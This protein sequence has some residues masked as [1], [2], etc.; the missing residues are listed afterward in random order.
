[1][2]QFT[3]SG[4][5]FDYIDQGAGEPVLLIHGF[6]S[7]LAV[8]WVSTG[9]TKALEQAGYRVIAFDNRGHGKSS[10]SHD[11]D[12]YQ[13]ELMAADAVALL[14][15]LGI[16]RAHV[17]GYSMGARIAAFMALEHPGRVASLI[18]GG[19]G[20][21][22]VE[23]V[24]DWGPIAKALVADD[25]DLISDARAQAFRKFADQTKSDKK[26]LAACIKTS[27]KLLG[28][29]DMRNIEAPALVAVGTVDDISGAAEPLARLLPNGQPF[30]I[31]RCDHMRAVGDPTFKK[32]VVEFLSE[33]P[34]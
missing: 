34:L 2:A 18:F 1:M 14:D 30:S 28:E 9:W 33:N 16:G 29:A 20:I 25:P 12:D 17:M 10:K 4:F 3:H 7:S 21:G 32:R 31:E 24:G 19:L 23:G 27:R 6:A 11:S 13:P 22:M 8:N 15:H 5:Q 26:A